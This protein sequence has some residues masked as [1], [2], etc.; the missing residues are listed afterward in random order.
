[1]TS[2]LTRKDFLKGLT[3]SAVFAG[4]KAEKRYDAEVIIMG[5]GLSGLYAA[6]LLEDGGKDVRV[7][8]AADHIGGRLKTYR[9]NGTHIEAGG[10]QIGASY[11]R[12]RYAAE[13]LGITLSSDQGGPSSTTY[14]FK[15]QL[16]DLDDWGALDNHPFPERFKKSTPSAALFRA[17]ALAQPL[18]SPLDWND[19]KHA[20][21]DIS[22]HLFLK[23]MG[24]NAEARTLIDHSLN[25]NNLGSYSMMNLYRS[26]GLFSQSRGMGPSLYVKDGAQSLPQ[27][28][29]QS[30][31]HPVLTG[32]QVNEIT[33]TPD[34]VMIQTLSGQSFRCKQ[35]ICS[36]PF[37]A[38][39]HVQINAPLNT[40]QKSAITQLPYTQILQIHGEVGIPFW[41]QDGL[42]A[43]M[44]SDGPM[45]R[46]FVHRTLSGEYSGLARMWING[47]G[48][49]NL[50]HLDDAALAAQA[51]QWLADARPSSKG[52]FKT[53]HIQRW[54]RHDPLS[55][56]AY[57][58]W[59]PGQIANFAP[60]MGQSSGRLH[61]CGEHL[62]QIHTGMEG[63][64]E[65]GENV[66]FALLDI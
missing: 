61:F 58:H 63:A 53:I 44:W 52:Q 28:M 60:T 2:D 59:A 56:G 22:A 50:F 19:P 39:K 24:F 5:A 62:S 35:A 14:H 13:K 17:A 49:E 41:E 26:L 7:I 15:G 43:N 57:M 54:S 27:A 1:M 64:M 38:L 4:C 45:E 46:L 16:L 47:R 66:A 36:L 40:V 37:G 31:R 23:K 25:A 6:M 20:S 10:E 3:A 9:H 8:E 51:R 21:Y 29:A 32:Q 55:G 33:V 12:I 11:A 48:A 30:L 34:A 42:P 18:K 65:S